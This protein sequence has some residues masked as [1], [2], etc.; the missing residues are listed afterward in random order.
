MLLVRRCGSIGS[1]I[2]D[3]DLVVF[4]QVVCYGIGIT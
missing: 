1:A 3:K 4:F 2:F